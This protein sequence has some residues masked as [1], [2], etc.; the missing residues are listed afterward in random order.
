MNEYS[1]EDKRINHC[2]VS[3]LEFL[4]GLIIDLTKI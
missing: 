2:E 1:S 3:S 4:N